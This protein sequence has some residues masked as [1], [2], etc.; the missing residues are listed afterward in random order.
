MTLIASVEIPAELLNI[1][2]AVINSKIKGRA[3]QLSAAYL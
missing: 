3:L 2:L 1:I